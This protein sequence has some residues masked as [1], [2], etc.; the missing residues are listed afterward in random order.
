MFLPKYQIRNRLLKTIREIGETLAIIRSRQLAAP[1]LTKLRLEARSLS[2]YASTSIEGNPLP[3][4]DVKPV[5]YT[6]LTLPTILLV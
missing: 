5:S 1:A 4:T 2:S 3:L 6:H